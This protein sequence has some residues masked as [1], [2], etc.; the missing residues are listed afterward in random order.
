MARSDFQRSAAM[1]APGPSKVRT[2]RHP[3]RNLP[4]CNR[5][6]LD[7]GQTGLNDQKGSVAERPLTQFF[8]PNR[9]VSRRPLRC[10]QGLRQRL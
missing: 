9:T 8:R 10:R 1:L 5:Q 7:R 6:V 3:K 2:F 4:F